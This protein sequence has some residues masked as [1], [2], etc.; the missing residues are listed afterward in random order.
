MLSRSLKADKTTSQLPSR[1]LIGAIDREGTLVNGGLKTLR[2]S[3]P[4]ILCSSFTLEMGGVH[5]DVPELRREYTYDNLPPVA[6]QQTWKI[7]GAASV[8]PAWLSSMLDNRS[9]SEEDRRILEGLCRKVDEQRRELI[10][11]NSSMVSFQHALD[12]AGIGKQDR[13]E[14]LEL[15]RQIQKLKEENGLLTQHN[16]NVVNER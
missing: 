11:R 16:A 12:P 13:G 3:L 2:F 10:E 15:R 4:E 8:D 6:T 5:G 14:L 7:G 1:K 9:I